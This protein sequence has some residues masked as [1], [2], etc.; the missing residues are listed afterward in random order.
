MADRLFEAIKG[1]SP[2]AGG[3]EL[4]RLDPLTYRGEI[5]DV[6][7]S[8]G[9]SEFMY[10]GA[11]KAF[12][13]LGP[14]LAAELKARLGRPAIGAAGCAHPRHRDRRLAIYDAGVRLYDLC[15]AAWKR[16]RC[17]TCR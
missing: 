5:S 7:F 1:G 16:C 4:L 17:A 14:E 11:S 6:S 9:V 10:G 2:R 3:A 8:G 15:F 13:D 12:G